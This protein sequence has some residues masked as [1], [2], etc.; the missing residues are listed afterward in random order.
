M[1]TTPSRSLAVLAL[2]SFVFATGFLGSD[3][4]YYLQSIPEPSPDYELYPNGITAIQKPGIEIYLK[5]ANDIWLKSTTRLLGLVPVPFGTIKYEDP[6]PFTDW[7]YYREALEQKQ[8]PEVFMVEVMFITS[9]DSLTFNPY[10]NAVILGEQHAGLVKYAVIDTSQRSSTRG[11][12]SRPF[13]R[14]DGTLF[15]GVGVVELGPKAGPLSPGEWGYVAAAVETAQ[16]VLSPSTER[17]E[18]ALPTTLGFILVF[19]CP[20][21]VPG[22]DAFTVQ[23]HGLRAHGVPVHQYDFR[24]TQTQQN[25]VYRH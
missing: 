1:R 9:G 15:A 23:L 16:I 12:H 13:K 21:P 8:R 6:Y 17:R 18:F 7:T 25:Q 14:G 11:R 5:P 24:F 19:D 3:V 4:V 22:A 20:T 10:D 2:T